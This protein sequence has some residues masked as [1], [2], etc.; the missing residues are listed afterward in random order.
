VSFT[1][2]YYPFFLAS[3]VLVYWRLPQRGRLALVLAASYVFYGYWDIRFLSL[4][5]ASTAMDFLCGLAIRGERRPMRT[6]LALC[7]LPVAWF[8]AIAAWLGPARVP[9]AFVALACVAAVGFAVLYRALWRLPD[10][11]RA[12]AFLWLQIGYNLGLLGF[13]KYFNFFIES[14][15]ALL[16]AAGLPAGAGTLEILLPVGI[17]FYTFQSIAYAV[18]VRRGRTEP[19]HDPLLFA[20]F[21]AFFPQLV[22][23]PIE[24][25]AHMLPQLAR[26]ARFEP[27]MLHDGVRLLLVGWFKKLFVANNCALV[28]D[29]LFHGNGHTS[30]AW[31]VLGTVAF[32]FQ[33]Y[34]DFSGYTDI[35]RGSARLLGVELSPNFR[36]PYAARGPS[37]FWNRWHISLS[38]WIRDYLYI[39]L[40]GNRGSPARTVRNLY[41]S[42]LL[43]G[44]WHG[45]AWTFVLWG[46]YHATLLAAYRVLPPLRALEQARGPARVVAIA[47][48]FVLTLLGWLIFRAPDAAFVGRALASLAGTEP[49]WALDWTGPAKWVA[50]HVVPLL[51]LQWVSRRAADESALDHRGWPLRTVDYAVMFLLVASSSAPDQEFIYFQF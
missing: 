34:G 23:G 38:S 37:D 35:A 24:R 5:M 10:A 49:V 42:M 41:A 44:L 13:F 50:L 40:G 12:D 11:R 7:A 15:R 25:A 27:A 2:W 51:V 8:A 33:I 16:A 47:L 19:C 14:A 29:H 20:T 17:S 6:V 22:A 31:V 46:A 43:A 39:P 45:A 32:A 3:V 30:A 21:I 1:A 18:D 48:M 4:I 9:P 28:A 26:P 36:A